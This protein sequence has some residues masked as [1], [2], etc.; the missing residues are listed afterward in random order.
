MICNWKRKRNNSYRIKKKEIK[1]FLFID[2]MV[3]IESPQESMKNLLE[4]TVNVKQ[5]HILKDQHKKSVAFLGTN[6]EKLEFEIKIFKIA[7]K[8]K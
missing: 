8:G 7:P 3:Y 2:D 4:I 6:S 5:C 1:L